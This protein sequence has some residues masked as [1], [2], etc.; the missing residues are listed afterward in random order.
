MQLRIHFPLI[1]FYDFIIEGENQN[2][3]NKNLKGI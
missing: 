1:F 2:N 3:N